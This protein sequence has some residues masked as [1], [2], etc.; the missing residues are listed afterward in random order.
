MYI[1]NRNASTKR[2]K[3]HQKMTYCYNS[4]SREKNRY[5]L[6]KTYVYIELDRQ[7]DNSHDYN[8]K[9]KILFKSFRIN[10]SLI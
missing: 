7:I 2:F 1:I 6:K 3:I 5:H 9:G 10:I 8:I 4:V